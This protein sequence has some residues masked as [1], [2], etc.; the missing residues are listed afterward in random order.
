MKKDHAV[1]DFVRDPIAIKI[2]TGRNVESKMR[3]SLI[4]KNPDVA[5][6]DLKAS[7]DLLETRNV[8]ALNGGKE[9][10]ALLHQAEEDW[11]NK[12]RLMARYVDRVADGD[13][14]IILSA[15]FNL[16]KQ[17]APAVRPEFSV[18]LGEK[19][20]SVLLQ[21]KRV[22]GARS[23]IWQYY[24]GETPSNDANW[25]NAQVTSQASVELTGLTPVIKYW[26]RVAAVTPTGTTAFCDPIMQVVI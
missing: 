26:F 4:F 19:S 15:G 9:A 14:A 22:D 16:A 18:E 7:T 24:I 20:G 13:S 2:E 17:P 21:R 12:M 8:A 5:Y 11:V 23:Y 3:P 1:L 10:T 6:D 25:V